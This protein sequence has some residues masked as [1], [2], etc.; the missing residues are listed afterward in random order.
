M[1]ARA[2]IRVGVKLRCAGASM[3]L[4]RSAGRCEDARAEEARDTSSESP[5]RAPPRRRSR[6]LLRY[7]ARAAR[8]GVP[9][10]RERDPRPRAQMVV[11]RADRTPGRRRDA[12]GDRRAGRPQRAREVAVVLA[13]GDR[14]P[15]V[16]D[17]PAT[18]LPLCRPGRLL[19]PGGGDRARRLA[20]DPVRGQPLPGRP[21]GRV[22]ARQPPEHFPDGARPGDRG[23]RLG[24]RRLRD[25]RQ[26]DRRADLHPAR[27]RDRLARRLRG[28][29][30]VGAGRG[31]RDSG[32]R[33]RA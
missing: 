20:V 24:D 11:R 29:R 23:R 1:R 26:H 19:G 25:S 8:R 5:I 32:G 30:A 31:G 3:R 33:G 16:P 15:R 27:V 14:C 28:A 13:D 2:T 18:A 7:E 10:A 4:L 17:L 12:R 9:S 21:G 22:P 6:L